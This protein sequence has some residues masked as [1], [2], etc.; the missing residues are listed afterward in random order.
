MATVSNAP[1]YF[2]PYENEIHVYT[3]MGGCRLWHSYSEWQSLVWRA[4]SGVDASVGLISSLYDR[5][6]TAASCLPTRHTHTYKYITPRH[7]KSPL[8][9]AGINLAQ[10]IISLNSYSS[11]ENIFSNVTWSTSTYLLHKISYSTLTVEVGT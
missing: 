3:V 7:S 11:N 5:H 10:Q 9:Q 6:G 2:E 4:G 8:A 1:L